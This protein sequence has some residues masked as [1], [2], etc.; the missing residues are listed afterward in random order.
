[1]PLGKGVLAVAAMLEAGMV[2]SDVRSH[3]Q[4]ALGDNCYY[5]DHDGDGTTGNCVYSSYEDGQHGTRKAPYTIGTANGKVA[6]NVDKSNSKKVIPSTTYPEQADD[7]DHYAHMEE[8]FKGEKLYLGLPLYERFISKDERDQADSG[9]FAGK[10]KS[11]PILKPEDVGAAVHAMGRA[12]SGNYGPAALKANIIKIAKAKG[13]SAQLPKEWQEC[14]MES[15]RDIEIAGEFVALKE[16]AVGQ[17]GTAYLKIIAPG[18]GSSGYYSEAVLKRDGPK[19]F[20]NGTKN[21]WN[22]P[23]DAEEA[24][25]P[26]GDL[27]DLASVLTEDAHYEDSGPA[28]P[29]L[30]ARAKVFEHFRQPVDQLAKHIGMSIRASGKAK[31]GTAPDGKKVPIIEQ[32]TRATSVDYVTTPGAGGQ[33][34]QLFEAARG[35]RQSQQEDD[36]MDAAQLR[37]VQDLKA[38]VRK[39]RER[40]AVA[41]AAG[42]IAEYFTTVRVGEAIQARVTR[43]LLERAVP[44]KADG[45]LDNDALKK[46]AEAETK[47][48]AAY[49]SQLTGRQVVVGMGTAAPA[50]LTEA[51]KA[52]IKERDRQT[53]DNLV[54]LFGFEGRHKAARRI[55]TEGRRGFDPTYNSARSGEVVDPREAA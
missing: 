17:D 42:V 48:E 29:G 11:Y 32:L 49:V 44:L 55:L 18:H 25:R 3:L 20:K 38:E 28:G 22:H 1:M 53:A 21:F 33:I 54:G 14:N 46:L 50:E 30:Y 23:T 8:A 36:S 41:D 6:A 13:W 5:L 26:E 45:A 37:E 40:Q 9:S 12:G 39:L 15:L 2:H 43:R 34:L 52:E 51:Q 19:V 47:D 24:A 35:T 4:S 7:D 27:R 10:G 16:G 31:E